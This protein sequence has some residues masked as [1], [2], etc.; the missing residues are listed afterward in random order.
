LYYDLLLNSI[1][2]SWLHAFFYFSLYEFQ[3]GVVPKNEC[4]TGSLLFPK[5][6]RSN[7]YWRDAPLEW[8]FA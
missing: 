2:S 1:I 8:A 5:V 7:G 3:M 6:R 4:A